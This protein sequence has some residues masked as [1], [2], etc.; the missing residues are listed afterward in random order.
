LTIEL[1]EQAPELWRD[2]VGKMLSDSAIG[3]EAESEQPVFVSDLLARDWI[4][5]PETRMFY[6][7]SKDNIQVYYNGHMHQLPYTPEILEYLQQLCDQRDWPAALINR[8]VDIE[9]LEKLLLEL[10]SRTAILPIEE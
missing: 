6:H 9:P 7:L 2:A 3:Q 1:F 5:H 8:C 10:A 4:R